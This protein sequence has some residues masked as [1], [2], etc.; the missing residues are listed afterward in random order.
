MMIIWR[1]E[2]KA[3]ALSRVFGCYYCRCRKAQTKGSCCSTRN[4]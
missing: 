1:G 2:K 4:T 3:G